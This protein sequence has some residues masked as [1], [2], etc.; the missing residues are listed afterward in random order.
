MADACPR[1]LRQLFDINGSGL[2]L[3][4]C[5]API[6]QAPPEQIIDCR[7]AEIAML[8]DALATTRSQIDRS[9]LLLIKSRDALDLGLNALPHEPP[10]AGSDEGEDRLG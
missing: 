9:R 3:E 5:M 10:N 8:R 4:R 6:D 1:C 2:Q 7:D